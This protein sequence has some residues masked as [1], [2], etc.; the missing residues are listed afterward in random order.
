LVIK[1]QIGADNIEIELLYDPSTARL[2]R[3]EGGPVEPP[4][5]KSSATPY[6]VED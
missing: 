2:S 1:N 4:K 5:G 3:L 6:W